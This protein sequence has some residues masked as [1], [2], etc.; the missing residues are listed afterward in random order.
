MPNADT[1]FVR[2]PSGLRLRYR[3]AGDDGPTALLLHG[4]PETGHAWRRVLPTLAASGYVVVAPDLR[5]AGDS[6]KPIG[7]YEAASR[8]E[9][10]RALAAALGLADAPLFVA[11]HGDDGAAAAAA[12]AA[13]YPAEVAGLALISAGPV[14]CRPRPAGRACFTKPRTCR[15]C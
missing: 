1:G 15:S 13:A 12:Y 2:L 6:D 14:C 5:G 7:G 4:W 3:C 9:D 11:G 8:M 10:V